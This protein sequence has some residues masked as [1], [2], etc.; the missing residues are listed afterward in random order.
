MKRGFPRP[1]VKASDGKLY[2]QPYVSLYN[3]VAY[4]AVTRQAECNKKFL[5]NVCGEAIT[6]KKACIVV[7]NAA[8]GIYYSTPRRISCSD[9]GL[10][11]IKCGKL[12]ALYY[13]VAGKDYKLFVVSLARFKKFYSPGRAIDWKDFSNGHER[14]LKV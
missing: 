12:T 5:C 10:S 3:K 8:K 11:H 2:P 14:L 13:P 4:I 1:K 9:T 6:T 7:N